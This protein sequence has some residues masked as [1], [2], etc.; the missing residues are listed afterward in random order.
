VDSIAVVLRQNQLD[1]PREKLVIQRILRELEA[2]SV[3]IEHNLALV[4]VVGMGMKHT[5]GICA[6]AAAAMARAEINIE[7]INQGPSEISM[8]FGINQADGP[9]AIRA[10]YREF[11]GG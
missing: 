10:L 7:M 8:I 5:V 1:E 4:A 11:F 3:E 9:A 6:R 2:D